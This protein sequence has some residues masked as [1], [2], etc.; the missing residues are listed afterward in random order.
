MN[1][2]ILVDEQLA[3]CEEDTS[4]ENT[5]VHKLERASDNEEGRSFAYNRKKN[6]PKIESREAF[7]CCLIF[8]PTKKSHRLKQE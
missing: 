3:Q 7:N 8:Y 5:S 4:V 2:L 1:W 6:G